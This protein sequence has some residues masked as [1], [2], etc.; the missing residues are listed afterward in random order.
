LDLNYHINFT[1]FSDPNRSRASLKDSQG[2][3][4]TSLFLEF[5]KHEDENPSLYTMRDEPKNG[6]PSAYLIYMYSGSEYEAAMK[7]VG[8]WTHWTKLCNVKKFMDGDKD[9]QSWAGLKAWRE[10]K[11]VK[12][13]ALAYNLLKISAASGSVP[14]QKILFEKDKVTKRGRPTKAQVE[15]A[16]KEAAEHEDHVKGDLARLRLVANN[17]N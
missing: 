15:Q 10:E 9:N 1:G 8:S 16:A 17:G 13:R 12:D 2:K 6:V 5:N 7:L 14:A 11:E 3:F 4:R